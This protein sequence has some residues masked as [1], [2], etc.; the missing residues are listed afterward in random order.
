MLRK[1]K[2]I[3][4]IDDMSFKK[5]RFEILNY[6]ELENDEELLDELADL[7]QPQQHNITVD[8]PENDINKHD[9]SN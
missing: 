4:Q 1:K 5:S 9:P 6:E 2:K 7:L 3:S 8:F